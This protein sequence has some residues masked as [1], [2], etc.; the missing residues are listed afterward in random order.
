M[1]GEA[2]SYYGVAAAQRS[3]PVPYDIHTDLE[4]GRGQDFSP[5]PSPSPERGA[6]Y[7][8]MQ[9]NP[10]PPAPGYSEQPG[11]KQQP[12]GAPQH[13]M[14]MDGKQNYDQK[15]AIQGPKYRDIWAGLLVSGDAEEGKKKAHNKV[16]ESADN[17]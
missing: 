17:N 16:R 10:Q 2:S 7:P 12:V 13:Q 3:S 14:E 6:Q 15:F 1:S 4:Q 9:P 8:P 11:P 5:S